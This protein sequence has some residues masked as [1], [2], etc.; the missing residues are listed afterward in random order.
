[1]KAIRWGARAISVILLVFLGLSFAGSPGSE[2]LTPGDT[3]KLVVWAGMMA[4]M[5]LAWRWERL[6]G[7]LVIAGFAGQL[8]LTPA[9]ASMGAMWLF[10]LVGGLFFASGAASAGTARSRMS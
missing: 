9:V 5:L 8:A 6:G 7:A 3:G 10:P 4:G 2:T 1:M